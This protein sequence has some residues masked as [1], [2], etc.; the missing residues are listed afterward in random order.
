MGGGAKVA[1]G[2]LSHVTLNLP[3]FDL[4]EPEVPVFWE[5]SINLVGLLRI[6]M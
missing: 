5:Y 1:D 4:C 6:K 3:K 2:S